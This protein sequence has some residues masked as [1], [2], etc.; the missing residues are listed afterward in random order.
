[1]TAVKILIIV[2]AVLLLFLPLLPL[3][4]KLRRFSTFYG[5]RYDAPD[6]RI[7]IFFVLLTILEFVGL[8]IVYGA[9]FQYCKCHCFRP[10]RRKAA[11][12]RFCF[13]DVWKLGP[14]QG[15]AFEPCDPLHAFVFKGVRE[16]HP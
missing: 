1:M 16:G 4:K 5:L 9:I 8:A 11:F 12:T 6:N 10:L 2:A 3:P 7:N 14:F 13:L 15:P